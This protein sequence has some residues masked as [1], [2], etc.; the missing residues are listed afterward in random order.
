MT[1]AVLVWLLKDGDYT[2]YDGMPQK[3]VI[4][5]VALQV[6]VP[7][8]SVDDF[9]EHMITTGGF[10]GYFIPS[11]YDGIAKIDIKEEPLPEFYEGEWGDLEDHLPDYYS[12]SDVLKS[13]ILQRLVDGEEVMDSDRELMLQGKPAVLT[14]E[15]WFYHQLAEV[16]TKLFND[17]P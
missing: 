9:V 11:Q 2:F 5:N 6:Y 15:E 3:A 16:V 10:G 13:D 4:D 8:E 14:D 12:N 7:A 17:C 1:E